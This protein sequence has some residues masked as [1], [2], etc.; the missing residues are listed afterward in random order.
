ML[1]LLASTSSFAQV[2][3]GLTAGLNMANVS[4]DVE[5]N[6]M[7]M[8]IHGGVL[9]DLGITENFI[10]EGGL[11]YSGKGY[12][13]DEGDGSLSF[14]YLEIPIT[15][16]YQLES[17]LNFILGPY[18]G[19][20][21]SASS[22]PEIPD[23]DIKDFM[24]STDIGL[25]VGLGYQLESG[26]GFGAHYSMGFTTTAKAPEGGGDAADIKNT[27]IGISLMYMFGGE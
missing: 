11:I 8:G 12:A 7:K 3:F 23:V 2:R 25:K 9:V 5:N 6:A 1:L 10:I 27:V 22:D 18:I 20:L 19:I 17:G 4:G 15:A 21:M 13:A 26:L 16:K 24:E 14:N